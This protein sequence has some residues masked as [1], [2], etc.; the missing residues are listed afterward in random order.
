VI[1]GE[2]PAAGRAVVSGESGFFQFDTVPAGEHFLIVTTPLLEAAGLA[3]EKAGI[4]V[5]RD[6]TTR[7]VVTEL[8]GREIA[9]RLC[10]ARKDSAGS[11]ARK[12]SSGGAARK[13]SVASVA[14]DSTKSAAV[15]GKVSATGG[16]KVSTATV[17][18]LGEQKTGSEQRWSEVR[19]D[20]K[21]TFLVC[22]LERGS[23]VMVSVTADSMYAPPT[24]VPL[25]DSA[26]ASYAAVLKTIEA[27]K[28]G[29]S[30]AA[31]LAFSRTLVSID[32]TRKAAI[33]SGTVRTTTGAPVAGARIAV[34][35]GAAVATTDASGRFT[36]ANV[37]AG[38]HTIIIRRVGFAPQFIGVDVLAEDEWK[39]SVVL[40]QTPTLEPVKI[41]AAASQLRQLGFNRRQQAYPLA[42][43]LTADDLYWMN[44]KKLTDVT[45]MFP[46]LRTRVKTT[47]ANP[48][49]VMP[50]GPIPPNCLYWIID[51]RLGQSFAEKWTSA[52]V[53]NL[54]AAD[55]IAGV[56]V[57]RA[58]TKL[59][60]DIAN[61]FYEWRIKELPDC[62]TLVLWTKDF[63]ALRE[64]DAIKAGKQ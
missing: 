27:P 30:A 62:H 42:T 26:F 41:T 17:R 1:G 44:A 57:Y 50:E 28:T 64:R 23:R 29:D 8:A 56:E 46:F 5:R 21:G 63:V 38:L 60:H 58:G 2:G 54:Y 14:P 53:N 52:D 11:V 20:E 49:P 7:A 47:L 48:E 36:L 24:V 4:V 51:K 61:L 33:V 55:S 59:P 12:D 39:L 37:S 40:S 31:E 43:F 19:L 22:G 32:S 35:S 25:L 6:E 16:R 13:D 45:V 10:A 3:V 9:S 34:D 18:I 15:I